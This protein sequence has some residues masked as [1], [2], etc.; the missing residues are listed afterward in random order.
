MSD[1]PTTYLGDGVYCQFD[2]FHF[3]LWTSDGIKNSD[4]IAL[5]PETFAALLKFRKEV[6]DQHGVPV[7]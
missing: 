5:E 2:G 6:Y 4:K 3:W 7:P 1:H